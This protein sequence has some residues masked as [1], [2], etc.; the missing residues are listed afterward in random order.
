MSKKWWIIKW[1]YIFGNL[2]FLDTVYQ[3]VSILMTYWILLLLCGFAFQDTV[4]QDEKFAKFWNKN[5]IWYF[6]HI[7]FKI[8]STFQMANLNPI[9][10]IKIAKK[11]HKIWFFFEFRQLTDPVALCKSSFN[12]IHLHGK[13]QT[14][15]DICSSSGNLLQN[16]LEISG[17]RPLQLQC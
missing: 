15:C 9:L 16:Q 3:C 7:F 11:N 10:I 1:I 8:C 12:L 2:R 4:L 5:Y 17:T 13:P 6:L 14:S